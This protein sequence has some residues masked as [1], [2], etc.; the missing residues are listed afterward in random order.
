M[1]NQDFTLHL[2]AAEGQAPAAL[3]HPHADKH[4]TEKDLIRQE[5]EDKPQYSH[6]FQWKKC[7]KQWL[8]N[9]QN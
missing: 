7:L 9:V 1:V 6:T 4:P 3:D 5:D 2:R 8:Q